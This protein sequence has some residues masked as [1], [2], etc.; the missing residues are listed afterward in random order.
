M[1]GTPAQ[2]NGP[3]AYKFTSIFFLDYGKNSRNAIDDYVYAY[4]LDNNWRSQ[5]ALVSGAR[6]GQEHPDEIGMGVLRRH[7]CRRRFEMSRDIVEKAA[8]L[9]DGRLLYT[10]TLDADAKA[11]E[12]SH[13][14][15]AC[16][17]H[18]FY[19]APYPWG[20]WRHF[21]STDFGLLKTAKNYGQY[22]TSTVEVHQCRWEDDVSAEQPLGAFLRICIAQTL[23]SAI[24]SR[25]AFK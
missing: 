4:G 25:D 14:V 22:G 15:I 6:P 21:L 24:C 7:Q 17:T 3:L 12:D 9:T 13:K 8:V 20:P 16:A 2:P 5:Q 11:C 23:S 19:E 1:F 18:E 10:A